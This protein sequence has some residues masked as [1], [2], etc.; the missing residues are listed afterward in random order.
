MH[1]EAASLGCQSFLWVQ[2]ESDCRRMHATASVLMVAMRSFSMMLEPYFGGHSNLNPRS[3]ADWATIV[4]NMVVFVAKILL[5]P[6]I[7]IIT[8][9]VLG[10]AVDEFGFKH[11]YHSIEFSQSTT[12]NR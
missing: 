8:A 1:I 9:Q 7:L 5:L 6:G 12:V 10:K 3:L 11:G 4:S 2:P